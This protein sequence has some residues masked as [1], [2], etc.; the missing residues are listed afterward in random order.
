MHALVILQHY[1]APLLGHVHRRRLATLLEAVAS[2][3]SG[4]ALSLTD[5]G[6]RFAGP[7]RLRHKI[8]RSD[9]LLGNRRLQGEARSIYAALCRVTLARIQEPLILIDWSDLKADQSLHL[10][11]ASLPVGGRSLTLYEEVHPQRRLNNRRVQE[12]FLQRLAALLPAHTAPVIVADAGF[13][14]PFYREVERLGWRW[15]GRV[16]G[17]D[18]VRLTTRWVSCKAL[19]KR[20]TPTATT[21]GV[22]EW[23]R[24]N[25]L[26]ALFVLV[27]Q[28]PKGRRVKT[29]H[30]RRARSKKSEQSARAARE[31]WLLVASVRFADLAPKQLMRRYRQRMQIEESFRDLKSQHFGE[32]LERSRSEGM[33]RFTVLVLI[34]TLAA[35]LLWLLGT[36]AEHAGLHRWLHPGNGERRVYSRLFLARLLLVLESCRGHL[37]DLT[38]ALGPL[39][40]WVANDHD[41]LLV[42]RI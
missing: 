12:R 9:R 8:K 3:V 27:R 29:T 24:S 37:D 18:Y 39:D 34:A 31:P 42:D 40:Q 38:L 7:V 4:P 25:P 36:A 1:L 33:G 22:G 32:G 20:A 11:R 2:C 41:A 15:V 6:R 5:I 35:F 30:G 26:R 16:R 17:R 10:L 23:V 19:F 21:L 14:V 28:P 13:K